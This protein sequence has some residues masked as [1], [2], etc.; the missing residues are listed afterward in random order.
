M[1]LMPF[2][3]A[4]ISGYFAYLVSRQY[5][6]RGK[7][8]QLI[9]AVSLWLAAAGSLAYGVAVTSGSAIFF[10]IFYLSGAVFMAA[11][12]G[13]GSCYLA[14]GPRVGRIS[15]VAVAAL[16]LLVSGAVMGSPINNAALA[17]LAVSVGSGRG[18]LRLT[19]LA[20]AGRTLLNIFGTVAVAGVAIKSAI[21]VGKRQ[22]PRNFLHG[23][24]LIAGGVVANAVAGAM[25]R[26]GT[27]FDPFWLLM[28]LGWVLMFLGFARIGKGLVPARRSAQPAA[29]SRSSA[30]S[31]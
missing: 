14:F 11:L 17:D 24:L 12:L 27:G 10:R 19:G 28:T 4:G 3:S 16:G 9:W 6:E 1:I 5:T 21:D 2:L 20:A 7:E 30:S 25:A 31:S 26:L 23:N 18:V 29:V 15:L 8:H 22:A 13:V